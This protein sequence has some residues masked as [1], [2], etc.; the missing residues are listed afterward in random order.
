MSEQDNLWR[1]QSYAL[2]ATLLAS[3]PSQELLQNIAAIEV[4]DADS[5]MGKAWQQLVSAS[6]QAQADELVDEYQQLFIGLTQGEV[7]PYGSYYQSGFLME[8]PLAKLRTDL[9]SLGLERQDDKAEP[10]D[11]AAAECDVMRLILSANGT[12]VIDAQTFFNRHIAPW[13]ERFFQDLQK[14]NSATFYRAVGLLGETFINSETELL[15]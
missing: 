1:L 5:E 6:A 11:H 4:T 15:K 8:K 9:A 2:L 7:I 3:A 10:E 12:P 14:A 13:M